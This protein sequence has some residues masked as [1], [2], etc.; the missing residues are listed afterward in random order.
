MVYGH[1]KESLF[2]VSV[3]V[4]RQHAVHTCHTQ[5]VGNELGGNAHTGLALTVLTGPSKIGNHGVH[6]PGRGSFG[7]VNH[8]QELHQVVGT[9]KGAL[10]QVHIAIADALKIANLEFPIREIGDFELSEGDA[11]AVAEL[12]GK[13]LR[14]RTAEDFEI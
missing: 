8:Q 13:V 12:F 2:L 3:E 5:Q 4:H 7:G 11:E 10:H 14:L 1:L 9:R 6:G